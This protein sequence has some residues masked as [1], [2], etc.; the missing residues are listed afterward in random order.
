MEW[1]LGID[2][3]VGWGDVE[4]GSE[5]ASISPKSESFL[6]DLRLSI[7]GKYYDIPYPASHRIEV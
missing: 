6:S 4:V 1:V 7:D 2:L 5:R 3:K